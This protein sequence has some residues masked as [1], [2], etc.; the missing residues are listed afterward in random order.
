MREP[1]TAG[2]PVPLPAT[3]PWEEPQR[4]ATPNGLT[5]PK[6]STEALPTE[7][8]IGGTMSCWRLAPSFHRAGRL[9][10]GGADNQGI[11]ISSRT[12]KTRAPQKAIQAR[13]V[14]PAEAKAR[15]RPAAPP[16][17]GAPP[18]HRPA[19]PP[20][21]TSTGSKPLDVCDRE[22]ERSM[23]EAAAAAASGASLPPWGRPGCITKQESGGVAGQR[24][25]RCG[26]SL[27][28][29][30]TTACS[31]SVG[32]LLASRGICRLPRR[33]WYPCGWNLG[34][35]SD[36]VG[37]R[38]GPAA[39]HTAGASC[40]CTSV[41]P[42]WF[43]VAQPRTSPSSPGRRGPSGR[44]GRRLGSARHRRVRSMPGTAGTAGNTN[45][46]EKSLSRLSRLSCLAKDW[47]KIGSDGGGGGLLSVPASAPKC[48]L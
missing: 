46:L 17:P 43:G 9:V 33:E 36:A 13:R 15:S 2:L 30:Q 24:R 16:S 18:P 6:H 7:L 29:R 34:P 3:H 47:C 8:T 31:A 42:R 28:G 44:R 11:R 27:T 25:R 23:G 12:P 14:L 5:D 41:E 37:G 35:A 26:L 21:G 45:A 48:A 20:L 32:L 22:T 1:G 39:A 10:L 40:G 38:T 4:T 19:T